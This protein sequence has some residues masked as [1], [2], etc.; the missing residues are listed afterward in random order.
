MQGLAVPAQLQ[1]APT[2]YSKTAG[3]FWIKNLINKNFA[4]KGVNVK[5]SHASDV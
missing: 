3:F 4:E 5:V 1:S 2:N